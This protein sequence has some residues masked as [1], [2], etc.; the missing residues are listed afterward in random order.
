MPSSEII[1]RAREAADQAAVK[2]EEYSG[3]FGAAKGFILEHFGQNGLTAAYVL[4]AVIVLLAISKL[5]NLTWSTVKF[6]AI[7]A[8]ALAFLATF[9]LNCSFVVAL[10]IS[11]TICSLV[12]LFKG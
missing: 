5:A 11:V 12:L 2:A 4:S 9:F 8:V 3:L 7:P 1:S 6:L 10:P